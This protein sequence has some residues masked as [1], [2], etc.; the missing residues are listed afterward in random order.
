MRATEMRVPLTTGFPFKIVGSD[1]IRSAFMLLFHDKGACVRVA[2][3][4]RVHLG[5]RCSRFLADVGIDDEAGSRAWLGSRCG[6]TARTF[7][8]AA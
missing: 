1:E 8:T 4:L 6:R 2:L 7:T 3:I 5:G